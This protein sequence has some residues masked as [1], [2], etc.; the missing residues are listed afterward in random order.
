[1]K[2]TKTSIKLVT[3]TEAAEKIGSVSAATIRRYARERLI[4]YVQ[5]SKGKRMLF[6]LE[7]VEKIF[8]PTCYQV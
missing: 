3:A 5:I 4:P 8:I 2:K 1:M 6:N 7:E